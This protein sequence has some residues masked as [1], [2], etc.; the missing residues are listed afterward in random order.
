LISFFEWCKINEDPD[1]YICFR[2][3][4][5]K[6]IKIWNEDHLPISSIKCINRFESK[7]IGFI[8]MI[9]VLTSINLMNF[10]SEIDTKQRLDFYKN[11][12][13]SIEFYLRDELFSEIAYFYILNTILVQ[14]NH[15]DE[16]ANHLMQKIYEKIGLKQNSNRLKNHHTLI[17]YSKFGIRDVMTIKDMSKV[18]EYYKNDQNRIAQLN[19]KSSLRLRVYRRIISFLNYKNRKQLSIFIKKIGLIKRRSLAKE[20]IA[21]NR[22]RVNDIIVKP[23]Y[24]V[25]PQ[26]IIDVYLKDTTIRI[27]ALNPIENYETIPQPIKK[28]SR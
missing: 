25:K 3:G 1:F 18:I 2:G 12:Q 27:R 23:S 13:S 19:T 21:K 22:I 10:Y 11:I 17:N 7:L 20:T 16:A 28:P 4:L 9:R 8:S 24:Q 15:T 26:D 5:L 14:S 6:E